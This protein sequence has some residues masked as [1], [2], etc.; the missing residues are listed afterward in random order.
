MDANG[1]KAGAAT[2]V[3]MDNGGSALP[4][5]TIEFEPEYDP[6][7]FADDVSLPFEVTY[8]EKEDEY[9]VEGPRIE[10]MLG[11]TN[12]ESEKGFQFFQEFLKKNGILV[13]S[14]LPKF[15]NSLPQRFEIAEGNE[16][17]CGLDIELDE[18]T[19]ECKKIERINFK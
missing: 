10:R 18:E 6:S 12:L 1:T 11:Y 5:E 8:D 4:Q 15:L 13:Q 7:V 16:R 9:V 17:L 3:T 14:V 2:A 19:G